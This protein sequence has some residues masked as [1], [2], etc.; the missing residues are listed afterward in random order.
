MIGLLLAVALFNSAAFLINKRLTK[1][2]L[3]HIWMFTVAVQV[4][5][6]SYLK[7]NH[8]YWYF[9]QGSFEWRAL[10][11]LTVLIP[12]VNIIFLN[13]YPFGKLFTKRL[14]YILVW[15]LAITAYER[16]A[17][18]PQPWGYF[19]YGWWQI[20]YSFLVYPFLLWIVAVYYQ[21]IRKIERE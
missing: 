19:N 5:T 10:L 11:V 21:W 3:V 13:S 20:S 4:L 8:A 18:L 6:D 14:L 17:L 9:S 16:I 2:Q 15:D 7:K 1:N 12:P